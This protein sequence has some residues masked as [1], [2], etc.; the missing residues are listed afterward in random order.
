MKTEKNS[1]EKITPLEEKKQWPVAITSAF[2]IVFIASFMPWGTIK[3][4]LKGIGHHIVRIKGL[5]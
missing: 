5:I 1:I 4:H 2:L 3:Y